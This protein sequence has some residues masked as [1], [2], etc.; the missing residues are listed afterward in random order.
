MIG[1]FNAIIE[2]QKK[3][4]DEAF[5]I[6]KETAIARSAKEVSFILSDRSPSPGRFRQHRYF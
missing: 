4:F 1:G 6:K 3:G 2:E 5:D